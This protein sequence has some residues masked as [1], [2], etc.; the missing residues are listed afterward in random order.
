VKNV[1]SPAVRNDFALEQ[2]LC[3]LEG[4]HFRIE[5]VSMCVQDFVLMPAGVFVHLVARF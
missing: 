4:Y 3:V 2:M 1:C 5:N